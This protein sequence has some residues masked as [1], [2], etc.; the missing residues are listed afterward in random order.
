MLI[1]TRKIGD[2]III[3]DNIIITVLGTKNAQVRLGIEA[4]KEI[5]V[6]REEVYQRKR[7]EKELVLKDKTEELLLTQEEE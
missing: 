4:P 2:K 5:S 7:A 3:E 1:L 6:D